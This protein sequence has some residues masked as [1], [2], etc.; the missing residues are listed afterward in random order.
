MSDAR[1]V[2]LRHRS[3]LNILLNRALSD[4]GSAEG[5]NANTYKTTATLNFIIKGQFYT[6]AATDNVAF[7]AAT[8]AQALKAIPDGKTCYF[9]LL[10]DK[11]G[12]QKVAQ[13]LNSG[14]AAVG[15]REAPGTIP[16]VPKTTVEYC[17]Y[18]ILKVVNSTG[19][20]W[21]PGTDDLGE[22][23]LTDTFYDV[24]CIPADGEN[25]L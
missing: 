10:I 17:C 16:K 13:G 21:I 19:S 5:T 23:S 25:D 8:G 18:G 1:E 6:K 7:S 22:A 14:E 24:A 4:A 12:N 9:L 11:D 15:G 3:L 2:S 20:E